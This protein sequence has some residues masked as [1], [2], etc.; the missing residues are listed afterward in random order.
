MSRFLNIY[1]YPRT[2]L[3]LNPL[4]QACRFPA[5]N[6]VFV[7]AI[8]DSHFL[9]SYGAVMTAQQYFPNHRILLYDIGLTPDQKSKVGGVGREKMGKMI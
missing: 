7:L 9:E 6:F 8:S 1:S 5:V 4:S 2:R 3:T